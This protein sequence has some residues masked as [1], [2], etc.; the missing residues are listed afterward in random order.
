M[1]TTAVPIE[2]IHETPAPVPQLYLKNAKGLQVTA[3]EIQDVPNSSLA[4]A[5]IRLENESNSHPCLWNQLQVSWMKSHQLPV[6]HDDHSVLVP[7]VLLV[8]SRTVDLNF[9]YKG[10]YP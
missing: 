7:L 6:Q 1:W 8:Q 9:S 4:V 2:A 3:I 10:I 5:K